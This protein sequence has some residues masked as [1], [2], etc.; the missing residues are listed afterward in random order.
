MQQTLS[1]APG[2][3]RYLRPTTSMSQLQERDDDEE[4]FHQRKDVESTVCDILGR[5]SD[6]HRRERRIAIES[7]ASADAVDQ[8][9]FLRLHSAGEA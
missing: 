7:Q 9:Q 3:L 5:S 8:Q 1:H 2:M 4:T 6:D